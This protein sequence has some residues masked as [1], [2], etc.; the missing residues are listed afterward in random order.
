MVKIEEKGGHTV[1]SIYSCRSQEME[2]G[3]QDHLK[4]GIGGSCLKSQ[5]WEG[6]GK[7]ITENSKPARASQ[8]DFVGES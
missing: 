3:K 5:P 7:Q 4:L 1:L 2:R 6:R 8:Q